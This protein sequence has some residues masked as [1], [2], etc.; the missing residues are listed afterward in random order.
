MTRY[1]YFYKDAA[2]QNY[3]DNIQ[4]NPYAK[5]KFLNIMYISTVYNVLRVF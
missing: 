3:V 1:N 2:P 4:G 5:L